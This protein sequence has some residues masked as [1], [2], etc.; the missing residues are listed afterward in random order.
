MNALKNWK[1]L[2]FITQHSDAINRIVRAVTSFVSVVG[3][4]FVWSGT[5]GTLTITGLHAAGIFAGAAHWFSTYAIQQGWENVFSIKPT[6]GSSASPVPAAV[7]ET[8][9]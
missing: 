1:K 8:G 7:P 4:T 3:I 6:N 9:K 5:A 2:P